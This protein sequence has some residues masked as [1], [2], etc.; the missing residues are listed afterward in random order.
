MLVQE[1]GWLPRHIVAQDE[2]KNILGVIP[3][4][5][6]RLSHSICFKSKKLFV[7]AISSYLFLF[8]CSHSYG[9]YV[10]DHSWADAYYRYGAKY[11]PKLQCC[12][13][14]TPVPGPRILLRNTPYKDQVFDI[15]VSAMTDL[16]NKVLF[17]FLSRHMNSSLVKSMYV[18]AIDFK[19]A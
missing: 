14:F 4:Y 1:T 11:Y 2:D 19:S 5:L 12:V 9:E 15:L 3:L 13:P 6:K 16:A 8:N 18:D 17:S 7:F 10:F